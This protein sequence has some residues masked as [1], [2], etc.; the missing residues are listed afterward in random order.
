MLPVQISPWSDPESHFGILHH[1]SVAL[2]LSTLLVEKKTLSLNLSIVS[3]VKH[4][5]RPPAHI[6]SALSSRLWDESGLPLL[7]TS[8]DIG[9]STHITRATRTY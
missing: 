1:P 2:P 4:D 8:K 5:S 3:P 7:L 6:A 9:G